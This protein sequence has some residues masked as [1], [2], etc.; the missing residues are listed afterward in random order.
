MLSFASTLQAAAPYMR[1]AALK[2]KE[3]EGPVKDRCII[4]VSST[5]GTHGNIGQVCGA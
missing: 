3:S 5:T 1:D 2:D 4:N